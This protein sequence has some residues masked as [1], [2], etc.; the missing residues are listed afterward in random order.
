[1]C[2]FIV[3]YSGDKRI[4]SL[5]YLDSFFD[6]LVIVDLS[7][8]EV[9]LPSKRQRAGRVDW[10]FTDVDTSWDA[11]DLGATFRFFMFLW[12]ECSP[13]FGLVMLLMAFRNLEPLR[14]CEISGSQMGSIMYELHA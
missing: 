11:I 7:V 2:K 6:W 14:M 5:A 8:S 10:M 9:G 1:M 3:P 4:P 12:L 13:K